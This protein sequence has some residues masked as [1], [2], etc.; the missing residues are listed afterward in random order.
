[1]DTNTLESQLESLVSS[2]NPISLL[3][4]IAKARELV[5]EFADGLMSGVEKAYYE[6]TSDLFVNLI[7]EYEKSGFFKIIYA[8]YEGSGYLTAQRDYLDK[9]FEESYWRDVDFYFYVLEKY[10]Q[11]RY[12]FEVLRHFYENPDLQL[13]FLAL[14]TDIEKQ[15]RLILIAHE[16]SIGAPEVFAANAGCLE[17]F[18]VLVVELAAKPDRKIS[19]LSKSWKNYGRRIVRDLYLEMIGD[20]E[21]ERVEFWKKH[22]ID[23]A[24]IAKRLLEDINSE[25]IFDCFRFLR[26][27][28]LKTPKYNIALTQDNI[29]QMFIGRSVQVSNGTIAQKLD[30]IADIHDA[31]GSDPA[32]REQFQSIL[33]KGL[34]YN[35]SIDLLDAILG[36]SFLSRQAYYEIKRRSFARKELNVTFE[37]LER[38]KSLTNML[39]SS[40]FLR[41]LRPF[42]VARLARVF[43]KNSDL[44]YFIKF[45][46]TIHESKGYSEYKLLSRFFLSLEAFGKSGVYGWFLRAIQFGWLIILATIL[47]FVAPLGSFVALTGLHVVRL[48][49]RVAEVKFPEVALTANFQFSSFLVLIG[50]VSLSFGLTFGRDDNVA[51]VYRNFQTTINASTLVASE[52]ISAILDMVMLKASVFESTPQEGRGESVLDKMNYQEG[53]TYRSVSAR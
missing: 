42:L 9:Y 18:K 6:N 51:I 12:Q 53:K 1:M 47:F 23:D 15:A 10:P 40:L 25:G 19:N 33:R 16:L 22:F 35:N 30:W 52:S 45:I 48:L 28:L 32:K 49:K 27:K 11:Y 41:F 5:E 21:G 39:E 24:N 4:S 2:K 3:F 50:V 38:V 26:M 37:H 31:M 36:I 34:M 13:Q 43:N 17:F 14:G 29:F 46:L 20:R 8:Y 44:Y 7:E